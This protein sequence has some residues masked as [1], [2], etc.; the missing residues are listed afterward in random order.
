MIIIIIINQNKKLE[1]KIQKWKYY[2]TSPKLI[3]NFDSASLAI[4][5]KVTC[6]GIAWGG[7]IGLRNVGDEATCLN[8]VNN[9]GHE[10]Y[11]CN[12]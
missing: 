11:A 7:T 10:H 5:G 4:A 12:I 1:T 8:I 9:K 6:F 2:Q 3:E